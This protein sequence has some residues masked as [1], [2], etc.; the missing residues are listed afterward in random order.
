MQSLQ[1]QSLFVFLLLL[2]ETLCLCSSRI[3]YGAINIW[4]VCNLQC[5]KLYGIWKYRRWLLHHLVRN[6]TKSVLSN[7]FCKKT[8]SSVVTALQTSENNDV[9]SAITCAA[10][11]WLLKQC[12]R[13]FVTTAGIMGST[14]SKY[15]TGP[16]QY[17]LK[18]SL[19][20]PECIH[21]DARFKPAPAMKE[22]KFSRLNSTN[23]TNAYTKTLWVS[24]ALRPLSLW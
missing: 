12:A 11:Y 22:K 2:Y 10:R 21:G 9:S 13:F 18:T 16:T 20:L 23:N 4:F 3:V 7:D 1:N 24:H 5:F 15:S 6:Q 17:I 8:I 14:T 19:G